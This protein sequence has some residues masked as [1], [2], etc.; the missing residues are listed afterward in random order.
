MDGFE[1]A[2]R[3]TV[4]ANGL[5]FD[6]LAW[7]GSGP[8]LLCLHGFPDDPGTFAPLAAELDRRVVAPFMRGYGPT[9]PAPDGRYDP[10]ALGEDAVALARELGTRQVFGHD[11][12]AVAVYA[13]VARDDQF[14]RV[15]T[16][17]VPPNFTARL[18]AHPRQLLRSWYV[19]AFQLPNAE[20]ALRAREF[21]L[22]EFL[23]STWSPGWDY[24]RE[25][26]E[27]VKAT[28]REGD[29]VEHALAY[30]RQMFAGVVDSLADGPPERRTFD[31]PALL[32]TGADDGCI[33]TGLY[34]DAGEEFRRS[35][36]VRVR[37]AG[38]FLHAE[39]P[40]VVAGELAAFL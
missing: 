24:P 30:Y 27:R 6:C 29:T 9:G 25:R 21:A 1:R 11:W 40:G 20:R 22:L 19:W 26:V 36:V 23:W 34:D 13:A 4:A 35:R 33:G 8:P 18:F 38:H 31:T 32:L 10:L 16:A 14:D 12:G 5:V 39:R 28:F 2:E 15:A 7:D 17:A 3:L 37:D